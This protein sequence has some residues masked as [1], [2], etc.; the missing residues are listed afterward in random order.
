MLAALQRKDYA[1]AERLR[2]A[3]IPL[4]DCRDSYNPVRVL[5]EAVTLAG[6]AD[7][8]PVLPLMSNLDPSHFAKVREAAMALRAL[9]DQPVSESA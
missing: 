5:H 1:T 7:M 2:A 4:E 3:F 6:I 9:N 8:G